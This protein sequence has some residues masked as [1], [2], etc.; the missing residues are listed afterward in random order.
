[1]NITQ[2]F[3]H[4][5]ITAVFIL[6]IE[7]LHSQ[8]VMSDSSATVVLE[9]IVVTATRS[10]IFRNDSPAQM[11][12]IGRREIQNSNGATVA[13]VLK[14]SSSLFL[15]D[16]GTHASLKTLSIRGSASEHV[17]VL[18]DGNRIN[19]FQNGLVD[20]SLI[21]LNDVDRI[22]IVRGGSSAL[23]G[24]DA[25]GGVVNIITR[26]A[27]S[28]FHVR[29]EGQAGSF[30]NSRYLFEGQGQIGSIG[31]LAGYSSER[32]RDNFSFHTNT[33]TSNDTIINLTNTDFTRRQ[34][35][36][37]LKVIQSEHSS[38][39]F[40][41]QQV[42]EERGTPGPL[43]PFFSNAARQKDNNI[44]V[45]ASYFINSISG[46][47]LDVKS[48]FLY[49]LENYHLPDPF[50]PYITFYKNL[51]FNVNPQAQIRLNDWY[52]LT[53]GAEFSQGAL[54]SADFDSRITRVQKA[55]YIANEQHVDYDRNVLNR[56]SLYQTVRYDN[57][58]DVDY[59]L[60]PKVGVNLRLLNDGD[61]RFRA[62]VGRSFRSPSFNDLYFRGFSNPNLKPEH[63]TSFDIGLMTTFCKE[64]ND[65]QSTGEQNLELTYFN[66][67]TY[68]RIL[69]DP[70]LFIPVNIGKVSSNGVEVKY[71]GRFF[72]RHLDV[73]A[74]FT[75]TAAR[76]RNFDYPTDSTYDKQIINIPENIFGLTASVN[77]KPL[78]F[79]FYYNFVGSRYVTADNGKSL[80]PY[81]V[82][83]VNVMFHQPVASW[84]I[85][86][87]AEINNILD[88]KYQV[89]QGYPMP[90][91]SYRLTLGVEY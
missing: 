57:I 59:A 34:E 13:D 64:T 50:F 48:H 40:S 4:L 10:R 63:S 75:F 89:F 76:K 46:I 1:M 87:K 91:R 35:F 72:D 58:T 43:G 79:N 27:V 51:F 54:E 5:L 2:V 24:A 82:S 74:N 80:S 29:S 78:V 33:Q 45:A 31:V 7:L 70:A 68:D 18:I 8:E 65:K 61:F 85:I 25:L 23:Y 39:N 20:L 19:S 60:T 3:R 77:V 22:E 26:N 47:Q 42:D 49:S 83:N 90:G 14:G 28:G 73:G 71:A 81:W 17:L 12:V 52:Q 69:F 15:K 9:E 53:L 84:K 36:L 86:S 56:I 41:L 66:V 38:M 16:Q 44:N 21:P 11:D 32:G 55:V 62:T 67:N 6:S 88:F 30:G 37:H